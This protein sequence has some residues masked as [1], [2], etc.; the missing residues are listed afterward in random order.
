MDEIKS[1][2]KDHN[3]FPKVDFSDKKVHTVKIL[4]VKREKFT[5]RNSKEVEGMKFSVEEDEEMRTILTTSS[6][7]LLKLRDSEEG[8]V[9][10]IQMKHVKVGATPVRTYDVWKIKDDKK[11]SVDV[12]SEEIPI[13]EEEEEIDVKDIPF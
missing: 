6:A 2:L 8:D 9:Y 4:N 13:I 1:F 5:D 11:V 10:E 3:I 7:L 12:K